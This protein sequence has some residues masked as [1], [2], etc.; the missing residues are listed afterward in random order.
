M[1]DRR[2]KDRTDTDRH[3]HTQTHKGTG[4]IRYKAHGTRVS[5]ESFGR[6]E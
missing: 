6:S 3:R 1:A 4:R 5:V 2:T